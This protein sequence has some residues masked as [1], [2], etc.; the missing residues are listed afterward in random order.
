[1]WAPEAGE[2]LI[3]AT[4]ILKIWP[5]KNLWK[6]SS[7]SLIYALCLLQKIPLMILKIHRLMVMMTAENQIMAAAA[8]SVFLVGVKTVL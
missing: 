6:P 2:Y 4:L 8:V 1:M 7:D 5:L 3:L